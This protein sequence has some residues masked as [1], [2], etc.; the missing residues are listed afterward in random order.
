MDYSK[1]SDAD[2]TALEANNLAEMSD[3]GLTFLEAGSVP[4]K[5]TAPK[6]HVGIVTKAVRAVGEPLVTM[7]SGLLAQPMS[8]A[9]GG[10]KSLFGEKEAERKEG[11]GPGFLFERTGSRDAKMVADAVA[12]RFTYK[13]RTP[14]GQWG[15]E[16]IGYLPEKYAE[17]TRGAGNKVEQMTG[18]PLVGDVTQ[19][20]FDAVPM[21]LGAP[22]ARAAMSPALKAAQSVNVGARDLARKYFTPEGMTQR[23]LNEKIGADR[24]GILQAFDQSLPGQTAGEAIAYNPRAVDVAAFQKAVE[25]QE[26]I[27]PAFVAKEAERAAA[28]ERAVSGLGGSEDALEKATARRDAVTKPLYDAAKAEPVPIDLKMVISAVDDLMVRNTGNIPLSSALSNVKKGLIRSNERVDAAAAERMGVPADTKGLPILPNAEQV[29]SVIDGLKIAIRKADD[30]NIKSKLLSIKE[31]LE[32]QLPA[33]QK[34]QE[35][36]AAESVDINRMQIGN[37]LDQALKKGESGFLRAVEDA[38]KT[39]TRSTGAP[40][41]EKLEQVMSPEQMQTVARVADELARKH[42]YEKLAS[43]GEKVDISAKEYATRGIPN[44]YRSSFPIVRWVGNYIAEKFIQPKIDAKVSHLLRNPTEISAF[45]ARKSEVR[46]GVV[47]AMMKNHILPAS[48]SAS[49]M[50]TLVDQAQPTAPRERVT[51]A[52]MQ[53]PPQM[54]Q[55]ETLPPKAEDNSFKSI[56][57]AVLFS[58]GGDTVVPNDAGRGLTRGGLNAH[59]QNMTPEA[60]KGLTQ[61]KLMEKYE[62]NYWKKIGAD[63]LPTNIRAQAFDAAVNQGQPTAMEMLRESKREDGS[64]DEKKFI[65]LRIKRYK[66]TLDSK[67]FRDL[68]EHNKQRNFKS[69]MDR[70]ELMK[71]FA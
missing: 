43:K 44:V 46:D 57:R 54:A 34:A 63:Q 66:G 41:F 27:A 15:M 14:E 58:E 6:P 67:H 71:Q 61:P 65:Q 4:Q 17:L 10:Y 49:T 56:M 29:V 25:R 55:E 69:W 51:E 37:V 24:A 7:G 28:R 19:T 50:E 1:L 59:A 70:I 11:D 42:A 18:S 40:R 9:A 53:Q 38:P 39:I 26:Q 2:L 16:V 62:Q 68:P 12:K 52:I 20:A 8:W 13:P 21:V 64:Y 5:P 22:A 30:N 31:Q 35:A 45:L 47:A 32:N 3:E 60:V 48:A 23:G 36:F 33:Y